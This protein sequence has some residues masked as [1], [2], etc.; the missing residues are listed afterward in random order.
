MVDGFYRLACEI[1]DA[2]VEIPIYAIKGWHTQIYLLS[3]P[4][5][6]ELAPDFD[7]ASVLWVKPDAGFNAGRDDLHV[8]ES[9]RFAAESGHHHVTDKG[10]T[11]ALYEK[12]SNPMLGLL[13]AHA[14]L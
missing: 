9:V 4:M 13:S 5:E 6:K 1:G 7:R 3:Q 12:F 2:I 8:L 10:L 14:L 11:D